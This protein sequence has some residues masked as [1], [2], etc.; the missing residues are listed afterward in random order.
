MKF[1]RFSWMLITIALLGAL[2]GYYIS[3]KLPDLAPLVPDSSAMPNEH[4]NN[5]NLSF[6]EDAIEGEIILHFKER[7]DFSAYLE[8]L[9]RAGMPPLGQID[10]LLVIRITEAAYRRVD[11]DQYNPSASYNY[12]VE[13]PLPPYETN[14]YLHTNLVAFDESARLVTGG[15]FAGRGEGV[16]VAVLDSG[17]M[18]HPYFDDVHTVHINLAGGNMA[19]L[20]AAHGNSVASIITGSEGIAADAELLIVRVL[21]DEGLGNSYHVSQGIV[22]SVDLGAQIINMSLGLYQ[23]SPLLRQ[24][25]AYAHERG[26]LMVAAAGNDGYDGLP[27]PAAY[28][29]VLSVTAVDG[30][31]RHALFPNKSYSIDFAA[32]GVGILTAKEDEGTVLFSGTSAAT[33]FVTGTLAALI[34]GDRAL[35]PKQAVQLLRQNLN[36]QG[37]PGKDSVY[38]SGLLDWDRLRE[39]F[40]ADLLDVALADIYLSSDAKPGTTMPIV[41]TVQNRGTR[42]LDSA[43]LEVF[44]N[45]VDSRSFTLGALSP[46]Q[47]TSRKIFT[48]IPGLDKGEKLIVGAQVLTKKF[49]EDI[50]PENNIKSISFGLGSR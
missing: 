45:G 37:A 27:F 15:A 50:R 5:E 38:G 28:P 10:K 14:P 46:S 9:T 34:S 24:A 36:D 11:L 40:N 4:A 26:V 47:I 41:V 13:R 12:Q 29:D 25:V 30:V 1:S 20:G 35:P 49:Q 39:R 18:S 48:P 6:P 32:P 16:L 17:I 23:D 33:P 7:G 21:N 8:K 31:S 42:W 2:T 3:T 44:I 43:H 22:E 19:G